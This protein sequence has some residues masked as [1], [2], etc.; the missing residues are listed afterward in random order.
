MAITTIM[1]TKNKTIFHNTIRGTMENCL[2]FF[3]V[4][5]SQRPNGQYQWRIF[6]FL[7]EGGGSKK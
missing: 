2:H 6:K 7:L 1:N 4:Q 5:I 3:D